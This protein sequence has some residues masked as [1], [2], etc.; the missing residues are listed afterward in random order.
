MK[1][2]EQILERLQF[3]WAQASNSCGKAVPAVLEEMKDL[4]KQLEELDK[5]KA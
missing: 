2:K 5:D 4:E 1:T 3:L